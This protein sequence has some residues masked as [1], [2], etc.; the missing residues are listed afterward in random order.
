MT[1]CYTRLWAL[2]T[3][4]KYY[5]WHTKMVKNQRL[6]CFLLI[7]ISNRL[8][9]STKICFGKWWKK[10]VRVNFGTTSCYIFLKSHIC[11]FYEYKLDDKMLYKWKLNGFSVVGVQIVSIFIEIVKLCYVYCLLC[12]VWQ[13]VRDVNFDKGNMWYWLFCNNKH[14][15]Q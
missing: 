12:H 6:W 1:S 15:Y 13:K 10:F 3:T 5:Q 9:I 4:M 2:I 8:V 7:L 14:N 11:I